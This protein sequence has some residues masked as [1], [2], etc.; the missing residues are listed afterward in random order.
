MGYHQFYKPQHTKIHQ[1]D[2]EDTGQSESGLEKYLEEHI[3]LRFN[4]GSQSPEPKEAFTL[5][6]TSCYFQICLFEIHASAVKKCRASIV[7]LCH[8]SPWQPRL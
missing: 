8:P 2:V 7:Y 3:R 5:C 4:A 1:H 6:H